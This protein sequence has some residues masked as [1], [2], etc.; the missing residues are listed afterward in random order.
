M[1]EQILV[2]TANPDLRATAERWCSAVGVA[3]LAE[4]GIG[5]ARRFWGS[6]GAV[7]IGEDLVPDIAAAGWPRRDH[8]HLI[9][10]DRERWW[11]DAVRIGAVGVLQ[12]DDGDA[13]GV[14]ALAQVVEGGAEGCSVVVIGGR[15]GVGATT[16]ACALAQEAAARDLSSVVIDADPL[17]PGADVVLGSENVHGLRWS[18]LDSAAGLVA[19]DALAGTLPV[20]D[21]VA[22]IAWAA[23]DP[24]PAL[25]TAAGSVWS[26]AVRRFD[27]VVVDHP[28][29]AVDDAWSIEV[30]GG[31]V[32]TVLVVGDDIAGLASARRQASRLQDHAASVVAV[33]GGR[34]AGL[35]RA[36]VEKTI[37]LP[38]V[39]VIG[40][41]R[42]VRAAIDHG[43]GPVRSRALKR[44]A[45]DILDLVG[46]G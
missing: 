32:L 22:T 7:V 18:A 27:L 28:R 29:A 16:F 38:V 44:P 46:L 8:V 3:P 33:M 43:R 10:R 41:D 36:A 9:V 4:S 23:D 31:S 6:A 30:L 12:A 14:A 20:R 1:A 26:A 19:P 2:L 5:P 37:G 13:A 11:R 17:G 40:H 25:P 34:R 45:R 24:E 39:G 21:G 42:R 35:G 15:G